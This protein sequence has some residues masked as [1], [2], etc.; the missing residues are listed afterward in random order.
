V[1]GMIL[2]TNPA[3]YDHVYP[4]LTH[5]IW[6]GVTLTDMIAPAFL[7]VIGVSLA[8]SFASRIRRGAMR[9]QLAGHM[10]WRCVGLIV[11]GLLL[12]GFPDFSLHYL[13]IPGIL[14]HIAVCLAIGGLL[15]CFTGRASSE[16]GFRAN[17]SVLAVAS[18]VLIAADW[19]LMRFVPVPGY[20]AGQLDPF[21]N[22]GGLV[23]R[24][25]FGTN[26]LWPWGNYWWDPDGMV[27]TLTAST[28]LILGILA[29]DFLRSSSS[30]SRK[31][32]VLVAGG[33]VLALAG[34]ALNP[35]YPI[36]KK[37]WTPSY[38]LLADGF[39]L[40]ELAVLQWLLDREQ[41]SAW[42]EKLCVP[43]RVFGTNAILAFAFTTI[44]NALA[45]RIFLYSS[46]GQR[47]SLP[48]YGYD[49]FARF[50]APNNASLLYALLFVCFNLLLVW[51]FYR[52]G[53]FLKL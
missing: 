4:Q 24:F 1:A 33:V 26:H 17:V 43:A 2:V 14:Q 42:L 10:L 5:A 53:I 36:N 31:L 19:V 45:P 35:I 52:K 20:G 8:F 50:L 28:N 32:L 23:D 16:G 34:V 47:L 29:G 15:H 37:V 3:S 39:C 13:R 51:P 27:T 18:L 12:N 38:T 7:F 48:A 40:L 22:M 6:N 46:Q 25:L 21:G 11:L 9:M 30:R 44:A 41:H 49:A